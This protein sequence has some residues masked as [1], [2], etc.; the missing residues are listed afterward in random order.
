V[1]GNFIINQKD[2]P[3]VHMISDIQGRGAVIA[4]K[5]VSHVAAKSAGQSVSTV[6]KFI[7]PQFAGTGLL[8][9][10]L[11]WNVSV[12]PS[13]PCFATVSDRSSK[14]FTVTLHPRNDETAIAKGSFDATVVGDR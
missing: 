3:M 14:G 13:Q 9:E 8:P 11:S 7:H 2:N 5:R 4:A 1:V 6:V 12:T 10:G